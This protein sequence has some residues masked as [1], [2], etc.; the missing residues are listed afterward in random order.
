MKH[1]DYFNTFLNDSVNLSKLKLELLE[2]RVE[3]VYDDL[4]AD[5][6]FGDEVRSKTLQGSWAQRTIIEPQSDKEFDGD[7]MVE[8]RYNPDWEDNP[9]EYPNA[10]WN[11]LGRV[12]PDRDFERK[13][14]CVR[15][16]Y[17]NMHIDFVPYVNHPDGHQ[18]IITRDDND[19]ERTDPA[20]FTKWM[21]Q[22]D[23]IADKNLRK[24]IRLIKYLRD[25][26]DSFTGT[27]SIILTTL[28]GERVSNAKKIANPSA[29]SDV[30]TALLT[31]VTDLDDW[32]QQQASK[33]HLADPAKTGLDFDERWKPESYEFFK[34]RIKVHA[35]EIRDAYY[36]E[37]FDESVKKW[38]ALFGDGFKAPKP[39][40]SSKFG[41]AGG[42][43]AA[44]T[45][46]G[47]TGRAG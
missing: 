12:I 27:K 8:L 23:D 6:E 44:A 11:A 35:E 28:L 14:R 20:A 46:T 43:V 1:T 47:R 2:D 34:K 45:T 31:I 16:H 29:Y 39:A 10:L 25:H 15:V 7:V 33:P 26:K 42:A 30:P 32:L 21:R 22:Q 13:C 38:Q 3:D 40:S 37:D 9:R 36:E 5:D 24:V 17:T 41:G 4:V 19:F 18:K